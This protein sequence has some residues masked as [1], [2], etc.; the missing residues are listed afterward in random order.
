M[1]LFSVYTVSRAF[2]GL[3]GFV[4]L[5]RGYGDFQALQGFQGF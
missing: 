1:G 5:G 3:N 4:G 2:K